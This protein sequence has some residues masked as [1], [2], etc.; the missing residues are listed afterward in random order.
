MNRLQTEDLILSLRD[1]IQRDLSDRELFQESLLYRRIDEAID[2]RAA[3]QLISI[4]EKLR[5]RSRLYNSFRKLD[6]LQELLDD[7]NI[8]EIMINGPSEIFIERKS[9][10]E[11]WDRH[12]ESSEKLEDIIQQIV[13][14]I[15]RRV[16]TASPIADARLEDGSRVHIVLP[17]IALKG[18]TITIRKFPESF[19][20]EKLIKAGSISREA[21]D[22]LSLLVRAGYNIF[23]SGGT[24]SGKSTFLNAL[25]S[26]I[27]PEERVIT[28][29]DS[30]ELNISQIRNLVRLETRDANADG[31][32]EISMSMLIKASLR[33]RPDRIIVGEVR[34]AECQD[35]LNAMNT[36]HD[37]SL[38]TGHGNSSRDM[39][40]RLQNM[41]LMA[42]DIPIPAIC[43]Q[44][45]SALDIIVHL[46]RLPDKSRKV[47]EISE[48]GDC[49]NGEIEI[50]PLYSYETSTGQL[51]KK[52]RLRNLLKLE[53]H[54]L[55]PEAERLQAIPLK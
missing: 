5:L 51:E 49:K 22:F 14:R 19:N 54:G 25:A 34:G 2:R 11:A 39:L 28:I 13:S 50:C 53:R 43:S 27:P 8:T 23:I 3:V 31:N 24:S 21:A 41:V 7:K 45:C 10:M 32:G 15:D 18:P 38:S 6:I 46:G 12:F 42:A 9:R 55:L 29:E 20:M 16:N 40:V 36:G 26:F 52:G 48:I 33:M 44:I 30:A 37:G 4:R 1:E 47:L 17:P 35:M